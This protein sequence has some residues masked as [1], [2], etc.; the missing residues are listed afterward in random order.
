MRSH[1]LAGLS[2][3]SNI[4]QWSKIIAFFIVLVIVSGCGSYHH[5]HPPRYDHDIDACFYDFTDVLQKRIYGVLKSCPEVF[6]IERK[7]SECYAGSGC[8]CY[9]LLYTSPMEE[10]EAYLRK[11]LR[12]SPA[13]PYRLE[14]ISNH[15][16]EVY[17]DGGFE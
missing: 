4:G 5:R 1:Y 15:R 8:I 6:H 12:T 11:H 2:L 7:W 3:L 10:L 17:F 13:V 16:I 14:P 9:E